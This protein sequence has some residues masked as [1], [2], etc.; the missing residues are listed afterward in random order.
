M[1]DPS[2]VFEALFRKN[3]KALVSL[4]YDLIGDSDAAKDVVQDVFYKLWKRKGEITIEPSIASYLRQ[5]TTHASYNYVQ[6][7]KNRMK[8]LSD[9]MWPERA[10]PG[11]DP[12]TFEEME[13]R[14][15]RAIDKLP[16]KCK[17]IFL[18]S[19]REQMKYREIA[20]CL[21]ISEKTV[22]NQMVIALEKLRHELKPYLTREFIVPAVVLLL[23]YL[24]LRII[25]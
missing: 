13:A 25:L 17:V 8:I 5:A 12:G 11:V 7:K 14:A 3:H 18:L 23:V 21:K 16:P 20:E 9:L 6:Q 2:G 10:G 15:Q 22:E 4:A 24:T 1:D 19:R